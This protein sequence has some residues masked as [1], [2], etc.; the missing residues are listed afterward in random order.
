MTATVKPSQTR[1]RDGRPTMKSLLINTAQLMASRSTCPRSRVG[2]VIA[3]EGRIL[4]SGYNGAPAGM[5][6]CVHPPGASSHLYDPDVR[7]CTVAVHAEANAIAY[8]SRYGV[9]LAGATMYCTTAPCVRCAQLII[10]AGLTGVMYRYAYRDPAGVNLL[11]EA[12]LDVRQLDG[13][14]DGMANRD[15]KVDEQFQSDMERSVGYTAAMP[16]PPAPR[17][18]LVDEM[19]AILDRLEQAGFTSHRDSVIAAAN[20]QVL[21]LSEEVGEFVG[22]YRRWSGQARRNGAWHAM[23]LELAD[24]VITVYVMAAMLGH[25]LDALCHEKLATIHSRPFRGED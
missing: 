20:R 19:P 22:E 24:V 10:N 17:S 3:R 1:G 16:S 11:R 9:A 15:V 25:D 5:P 8:A 14:D 12:G 23:G 18:W 13:E 6:H 21:A 2:T 7:S 4:S